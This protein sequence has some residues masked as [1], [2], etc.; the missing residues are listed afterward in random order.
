MCP[1]CSSIPAILTNSSKLRTKKLLCRVLGYFDYFFTTV[2]TLEIMLKMFA[3]GALQKGGY[4]RSPG[5]NQEETKQFKFFFTFWFCVWPRIH[6]PPHSK[7]FG[8]A[9]GR[10]LPCF[11][12]LQW[13]VGAQLS[14]F[15]DWLLQLQ[16][17]R[18]LRIEDPSCVSR[19]Q[20]T[21]CN[22]KG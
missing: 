4:M 13:Q 18:S 14:L 11:H 20:A 16:R 21:S 17:W 5:V 2:F 9:R 19:S 7:S 12:N 1:S 6:L 22:S 8:H 10:S 15:H 3:Y